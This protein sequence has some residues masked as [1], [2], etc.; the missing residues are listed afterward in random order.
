VASGD[1]NGDD[2]PVIIVEISGVWQLVLLPLPPGFTG[3]ATG[4]TAKDEIALI[5]GKLYDRNGREHAVYWRSSEQQPVEHFTLN[6]LAALVPGGESAA[7]GA[8]YD[9]DTD[10][11]F[12]SGSAVDETGEP[13]AVQWV[14]ENDGATYVSRLASL[15]HTVASAASWY[16]AS[17]PYLALAGYC[18]TDRGRTRPAYWTLDMNNPLITSVRSL[19]LG[20]W[21]GGR[22]N[23]IIAILIGLLAPGEVHGPYGSS[24][25]L[26]L[27]PRNGPA[28]FFDLNLAVDNLP[29]GAR[30]TEAVSILPYM[31]QENLYKVIAGGVGNG[32]GLHAAIIDLDFG[33]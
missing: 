14:V 15:P 4:I 33:Q 2:H 23:G 1:F 27:A 17:S 25:A 24:A 5:T 6:Y 11:V 12:F 20:G 29:P 32:G 7:T 19:P 10:R 28:S 26:W 13:Q 31:E 30:L 22:V 16:G 21:R 18:E 3:E 9:A 8:L